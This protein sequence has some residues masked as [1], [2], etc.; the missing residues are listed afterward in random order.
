M[1]RDQPGEG[2]TVGS[3][4]GISGFLTFYFAGSVLSPVQQSLLPIRQMKLNEGLPYLSLIGVPSSISTKKIKTTYFSNLSISL[5]K[6]FSVI[7]VIFS[8]A[9]K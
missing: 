2:H 4:Q 1:V 3:R 8:R 9:L 6:L 5:L 7:P